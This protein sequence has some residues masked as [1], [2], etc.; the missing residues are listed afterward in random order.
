MR[1]ICNCLLASW[2]VSLALALA[3]AP[4][5]LHA[6][7]C[8]PM[9]TH[10]S[11]VAVQTGTTSEVVV[12]GQQNFAGVY[13]VLVEGTGVTAEP[14]PDPKE[15]AT[16]NQVKLKVTVAADALLG[17]REFR[18]VSPLGVSS[19]GQL[20]VV[21]DPVVHEPT[22]P[23]DTRQQASEVPVPAV[24]CGRIEAITDVDWFR[25]TVQA[26]Q[27]LTFETHCARLQD[28]IHDLQKHANPLLTLY[29]S[30]GRE[31]AANDSGRFADALLS[32]TFQQA[33]TYYLQI[34]DSRY[35]GDPR[36]VY[37]LSI[38]DRPYVAH[39]YPLAAA[40]GAEAEFAPVGS[41][42]LVAQRFR[43]LMPNAPG[44]HELVPIIAGQRT[45][46]VGLIATHLPLVEE[47]EPNDTPATAN[48]L[49]IP[50][51]VNGRIQQRRDLDHFQF[52]AT[53]GKAI[54]FE[55]FAR[56]FGYPLY[57]SMDPVLE[58]LDSKGEIIASR[59]DSIGKDPVLVF[60]P[61]A[62][63]PYIARIRDLHSKGGE[64][65]IYFLQAEWARPQF[66]LRFDPSKGMIGPGSRTAGYVHV[67]RENGFD[68]PVQVR[69][70][71]LPRGVTASE[72][73]IPPTMTQGVV[74]F[75]AAAD[76]PKDAS[77]IAVIGQ[78][79]YQDAQG[80]T[81]TITSVATANEE[82]YLPG[83]GRG[84]FDVRMHSFAVTDPSDI[85]DVMV[86]PQQI[87]LKPGQEVKLD[88]QVK[89]R[90]GFDKGITLDVM[91]R[92]LNAVY[93][94]PLPP[95]VTLVEGKSKTLLGSGSQG[96]ITLKAAANAAPI[97]S[98][99]VSVLAHTSVNFVVK[100]SY[101][102]PAL[103]LSIRR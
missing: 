86:T 10:A 58:I 12:A 2:L 4:T 40:V 22:K 13:R 94:N 84:R 62:D 64:A 5:A 16:T 32:Y 103:P 90:P 63:G 9:I 75:S 59:D 68:G 92:H 102:S 39:A 1:R 37:A 95:G 34:R 49:P 27:T 81:H 46:P 7:T 11:P 15:P 44:L 14:I 77:N 8:F 87:V 101:S 74:V 83:G 48:R 25:F 41:A 47:R 36:W 29:D 99:P 73:T 53:K 100:M 23:N 19:T 28:K 66:S 20:L 96:H 60:T 52:Q 85:L 71:G 33:G 3:L 65:A 17:V 6:Q 38:S 97:E 89:R 43:L 24:V 80:Q 45:N 21:A 57:A 50:A 91:L 67:V 56:R 31:L 55:V 42:R 54:R 82:I 18:V 93:G 78:G 26:G 76:A 70:D 79:T 69:V 35:D 72:L 88:V 30:D 51:G 61:P 98:V